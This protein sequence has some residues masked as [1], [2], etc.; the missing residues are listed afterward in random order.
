M[1]ASVKINLGGTNPEG[2]PAK[3]GIVPKVSVK[4]NLNLGHGNG[5]LNQVS[6][7][8]GNNSQTAPQNRADVA[9]HN[10]GDR[11]NNGNGNN[12]NANNNGNNGNHFG[13]LKNG[14]NGN[15][16]NGNNGNGNGRV[17]GQGNG[18]TNVEPVRTPVITA[19]VQ[20]P[21]TK[22]T[23]R[24]APLEHPTTPTGPGKE[25]PTNGPGRQNPLPPLNNGN[26]KQNPLP[27][28]ITTKGQTVNSPPIIPNPGNQNRPQFPQ[29]NQPIIIVTT[30]TSNTNTPVGIIRNA[31]NEVL[32]QN[33][34]Y[35]SRNAVNSLIGNQNGNGNNRAANIPSEVRNL[36]QSVVSGLTNTLTNATQPNSHFIRQTATEISNNLQPQINAARDILIFTAQPDAKHFSNLNI[37]ERVFLAVELMFNHLPPETSLQNLSNKEIYNGLMLARGMIAAGENTADIRNLVA[38]RSDA[39]PNG[40]SP[41]GLRDL[42]QLVKILI[43]SAAGAQT[44]ANLDVAVQKFIK[45]L[46]ANNE[47]GVLLAAATLAK[48]AE[49]GTRGMN[50]TLA[51]VQIYQLIGRLIVAGEA[52]LKEVAAKTALVKNENNLTSVSLNK[53]TDAEEKSAML[54]DLQNNNLHGNLKNFLEFNPAFV[55]E[56]SASSFVYPDDARHAQQH[57]T[58]NSHDEIQQWLDSGNHRF[59]KE[60]DLDKPIGIVVERGAED[61]FSASRARIV[62][63]RDSSEQ[64]WHFLKSF[65][66][67]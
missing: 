15:H 21:I 32:R 10:A 60:I 58:S 4:A 41:A 66:V 52:A 67:R 25:T 31:V 13:Q 36:V 49:V 56:R 22:T 57:F 33:D 44:T 46:V 38:F 54:R 62:L 19:E 48:Q 26:G 7:R 18:Q 20:T 1:T 24:T 8:M 27:P 28:P 34:I 45:L 63:V 35:V 12:G 50:R 65:L 43:V 3:N 47:M 14:N 2:A 11:R 37:Q 61:F 42:G 53:I 23:V 55:V 64:G 9:L 40:F 16:G 5:G 29:T 6:E 30:R 59:V 39:L 17:R 51:L